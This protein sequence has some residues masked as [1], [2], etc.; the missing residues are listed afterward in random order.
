MLWGGMAVM[1]LVSASV[2]AR[3]ALPTPNRPALLVI[4]RSV[5]SGS[6]AVPDAREGLRI[7]AWNIAHGRGERSGWSANWRGGGAHERARRLEDIGRMLSEIAPDVAVLN[8]ADIDAAWS[9]ALSHAQVL[10]ARSGLP[11]RLQQVNYDVRVG[12]N[13]YRFGNA[14]LSRFPL[15]EPAHLAWPS[16]GVERALVGAKQ[17]ASVRLETGF[18]PVVVVPVHLDPRS[19]SLRRGAVESV[20]ALRARSDAPLI[21]AGDFNSPPGAWPGARSART[22]LDDLL[23]DGFRWA[24]PEVAASAS[25]RATFPA[26]DPEV[27]LDW[28][29]VEPPLEIVRTEVLAGAG[30]SDHLPVTAEIRREGARDEDLVP[31]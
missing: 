3:R 21:L 7:V 13:R 30:L 26:S 27:A 22:V 9:G 8:E 28:I 23:D 14:V 2:P 16:F 17:G 24:P 29:L 11:H 20:R 25:V 18:G 1:I 10:G 12:P 5:A 15:R 6:P 19:P 4:D 31:P